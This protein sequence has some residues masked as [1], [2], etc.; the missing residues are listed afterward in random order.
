MSV[1]GKQNVDDLTVHDNY[2]DIT[3]DTFYF[4]L[5]KVE[6]RK[7]GHIITDGQT[8]E[9]INFQCR[10]LADGTINY[11]QFR[12]RA[13]R[14]K[15][16]AVWEWFVAEG[17]GIGPN[18]IT[19]TIDTEIPDPHY[20]ELN[21]A[22][23]GF[24]KVTTV[25]NEII[26]LYHKVVFGQG[27]KYRFPRFYNDWYFGSRRMRNSFCLD[28]DSSLPFG[29]RFY[30]VDGRWD[31]HRFIFLS[32]ICQCGGPIPCDGPNT[33]NNELQAVCS[34]DNMF[35]I[36]HDL[37]RKSVE[38]DYIYNYNDG[39]YIQLMSVIVGLSLLFLTIGLCLAK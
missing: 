26:D 2:L 37:K 32:P 14:K 18:Q 11:C 23:S 33:P 38:T 35:G 3:F 10:E 36:N 15:S 24:L 9:S 19:G 27:S 1:N 29:K 20:S 8:F 25:D 7:S 13:G 21:F 34:Q 17:G 6:F 39:G 16:R 5:K 22:F 12:V 31:P 28:M 30:G 4:L